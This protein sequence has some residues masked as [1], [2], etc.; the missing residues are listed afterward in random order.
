MKPVSFQVD[1]MGATTVLPA[2]RPHAAA[3]RDPA[4]GG[5]G[6]PVHT[7][8]ESAN[9]ARSMPA[10]VVR[11]SVGD[12]K[13][14]DSPRLNGL[15]L[16]HV[17]LLAESDGPLPPITVNAETMRVVDGMHRLTAARLKGREAIEATF[18]HCDAEDAFRAGVEA[19]IAHGLP[20][21]LADRKA[22]AARII[23]ATPTMSDRGIARV[24]GLAHKTVASIR[25]RSQS[26]SGAE[27]RVGQDGRSRPLSAAV[28]RQGA[29]ELIARKPDASLRDIAR[30]AG[31]SVGTARDVRSR[32]RAGDS[33][34]PTRVNGHVGVAR[35]GTR[36]DSARQDATGD[37]DLPEMLDSLRRDPSLRYTESGR[38]L[39][40]WLD[41]RVVTL[42]QWQGTA[43][44]V[45]PHCVEMI[46][47]VARE[48]ARTWMAVAEAVARQ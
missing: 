12:L 16:E 42:D 44:G 46:E 36:P 40:R 32:V 10:A 27:I 34:V 21:T 19:N 24:T 38:A 29:S 39:L 33:P 1:R 4:R 6:S 3:T 23:R 48:C 43:R 18:I 5:N 37:V 28:G 9:R 15:D 30:T 22:A 14:A 47:R 26:G 17:R 45:P 8:Q 25:A 13:E 11:V 7:M 31:I 35:R 20:L 41:Q 2:S